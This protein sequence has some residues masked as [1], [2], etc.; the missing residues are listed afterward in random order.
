MPKE[1]TKEERRA[2]GWWRSLSLN[3]QKAYA[4]EVHGVLWEYTWQ[5][6]SAIVEVWRAKGQ[7]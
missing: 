5:I 6:T 4:K 2:L 7:A 1:L 3:E